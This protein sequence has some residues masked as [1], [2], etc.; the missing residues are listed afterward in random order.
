LDKK[1]KLNLVGLDGNAFI[2]LA[3]FGRA[4]RK[5]GWSQEDI[6][7]VIEDATSGNYDHLLCVLMEHTEPDDDIAA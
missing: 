2:L 3:Q 1:V 5:Q 6:K 4:A 7:A